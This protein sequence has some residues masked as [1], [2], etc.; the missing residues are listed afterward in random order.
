M[1]RPGI[2]SAGFALFPLEART[3]VAAT[4]GRF[5][6]FQSISGAHRASIRT[7]KWT[8]V[9]TRDGHSLPPSFPNLMDQQLEDLRS[10]ALAAIAVA[11]DE[12]AVEQAR[13]KFLGQ[14]GA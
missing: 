4:P 8:C 14:A 7:D 5:G 6:N 11:A 9:R 2:A 1:R 12:T 13:I 10:E 3:R